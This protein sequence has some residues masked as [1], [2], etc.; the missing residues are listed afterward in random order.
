MAELLANEDYVIQ[1]TP[2]GSWTP[3]P[4]SGH[5]YIETKSSKNKTNGKETLVTVLGWTTNGCTFPPNSFVSGG[6]SINATSTKC[7]CEAQFPLRKNDQGLCNG[8]FNPPS[9]PPIPCNCTFKIQ[10]AGQIKVKGE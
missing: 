3:G 6:G 2:N 8:T 5:S 4:A 1:I 10:S 9:G 7:K